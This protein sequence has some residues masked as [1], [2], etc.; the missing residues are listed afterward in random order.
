MPKIL[1]VS[2]KKILEVTTGYS[3]A[4]NTKPYP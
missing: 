3:A 1:D 2:R 4:T